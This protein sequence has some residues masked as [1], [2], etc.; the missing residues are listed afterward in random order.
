[1]RWLTYMVVITLLAVSPLAAADKDEPDPVSVKFQVGVGMNTGNPPAF[2]YLSTAGMFSGDL[3]YRLSK[4]VALVPAS[5]SFYFYSGGPASSQSRSGGFVE[6]RTGRTSRGTTTV[7]SYVDPWLT[8]SYYDQQYYYGGGYGGYNQSPPLLAWAV[9]MTPGIKF[10]THGRQLFNF[11]GQL[12]A[13][14][15]S[16]NQNSSSYYGV[17]R[18]SSTSFAARG[19]AGVEIIAFEYVNFLVGGGYMWVRNNPAFNGIVHMNMGFRVG[20]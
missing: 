9:S 7:N 15:Y 13:G 5:L 14:V 11:Y 19:E 20:F 2:D 17:D 4:N 6:Q 18:L 10:Q 12:G 1:M 8:P 16:H 3:H